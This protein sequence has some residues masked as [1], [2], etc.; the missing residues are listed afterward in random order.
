MS[1]LI[2]TTACAGFLAFSVDH[3]GGACAVI[4]AA[5]TY[6]LPRVGRGPG[7]PLRPYDVQLEAARCDEYFGE[8]G[9]SSL[10]REGQTTYT[11]PG[12]D[13]YLRGRAWA[14]KGRPATETR[15]VCAV[16]PCT[17]MVRVVGARRWARG[18]G[19][20][21]P[22]APEPFTTVALRYELCVGGP[23]EAR[24]PVGVGVYRDA[25]EAIGMPLPQIE[26]DEQLL[27]EWSERP[28]P[29]GLGPVA[30]SWQPRLGYAGTY[31]QAWLASRAPLWPRDLD[32][33]FFHAAAPGLWVTPHL[34][35]G[36]PVL[37]RGCHPDGDVRFEL[38][39]RSLVARTYHRREGMREQAMRLDAVD[40]DAEAGTVQ[41]VWRTSATLRG[42]LL[43]HEA[44]VVAEVA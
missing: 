26:D 30:R 32:A 39:R 6:A 20:P 13:I 34:R 19:G 21:R 14:P 10:R 8:P 18:V 12:T 25:L 22:S 16:G 7:E 24:N 38:P 23:T 1:G 27:R 4:V 40:I 31:D 15:V 35:G 33:R 42:G 43:E 28:P 44:T 41:L 3:D 2:N 36:E 5:A 17:R 11:R 9:A 37:L 29:A